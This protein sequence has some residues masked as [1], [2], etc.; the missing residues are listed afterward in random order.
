MGCHLPLPLALVVAVTI[1]TSVLSLNKMMVLIRTFPYMF[2]TCFAQS[3]RLDVSA[4][5]LWG[6]EEFWRVPGP[7]L[8]WKPPKLFFFF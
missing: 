1:I 8:C 2:I 3:V 5:P 4:D 7:R 6:T